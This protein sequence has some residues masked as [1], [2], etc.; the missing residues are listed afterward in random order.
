[1]P[2]DNELEAMAQKLWGK[3]WKALSGPEALATMQC[4]IAA[5]QAEATRQCGIALGWLME[6]VPA[7]IKTIG[8]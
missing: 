3:A 7:A 8:K 6:T 1:M 5:K 4:V 2:N